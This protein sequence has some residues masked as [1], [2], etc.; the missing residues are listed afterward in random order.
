[1]PL[2]T[3]HDIEQLLRGNIG[4]E[5]LVVKQERAPH[6]STPPSFL[7]RTRLSERQHAKV[8]FIETLEYGIL[9]GDTLLP[10]ENPFCA[11]IP[12]ASSLLCK[13]GEYSWSPEPPDIYLTFTYIQALGSD[14]T[15]SSSLYDHGLLVFAGEGIAHH[16]PHARLLRALRAARSA[17][18]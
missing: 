18:Q 9:A 4:R 2:P 6:E 17:S 13:S 5:I 7:L 11:R 10:A 15:Y 1:M 3:T 16:L 8:K 12:T 14:I